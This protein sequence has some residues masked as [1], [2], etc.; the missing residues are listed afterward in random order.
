MNRLTLLESVKQIGIDLKTAFRSGQCFLASSATANI[1][2]LS[3][4]VKVNK[5]FS[6]NPLKMEALYPI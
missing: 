5:T 6:L 4:N 1:N 2:A 3:G